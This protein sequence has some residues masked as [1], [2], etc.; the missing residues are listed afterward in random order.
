MG[1]PLTPEFSCTWNGQRTQR[2]WPAKTMD[3]PQDSNTE[4]P[5]QAHRLTLRPA[6]GLG[7]T[8]RAMCPGMAG[9]PHP[10]PSCHDCLP[11]RPKV[12]EAAHMGCCVLLCSVTPTV[13]APCATTLFHAATPELSGSGPSG[14]CRGTASPAFPTP[15]QQPLCTRSLTNHA[16]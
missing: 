6:P 12:R 14:D 2:R 1:C 16:H 8:H 9:L 5:S 3:S 4:R 7:S 13:P 15:I 11:L 10:L